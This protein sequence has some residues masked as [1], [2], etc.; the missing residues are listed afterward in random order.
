MPARARSDRGAITASVAVMP[1]VFTLFFVVIQVSLWYHGRSVA[2]AAAHHALEAARSYQVADRQGAGEAAGNEFLDQVG[3]FDAD[4]DVDV[5][6]GPEEITVTVNGSPLTVVP[7]LQKDVE[8]VLSG[9]VE[10]IV[11]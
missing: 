1:M 2:L 11:P 3:G 6:V 10:R 9:P 8:V 5:Q 4:P 7:G